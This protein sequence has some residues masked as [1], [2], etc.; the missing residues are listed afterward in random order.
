MHSC[1]EQVDVVNWEE[2]PHV[3]GVYMERYILSFSLKN[4]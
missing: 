3:T 1:F 2:S 4:F